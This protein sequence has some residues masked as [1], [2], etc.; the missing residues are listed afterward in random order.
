MTNIDRIK[1]KVTRADLLASVICGLQITVD[2]LISD[3]KEREAVIEQL[4]SECNNL[5]TKY[6]AMVAMR[7]IKAK[8]ASE[9]EKDLEEALELSDKWQQQ[10]SDI[11]SNYKAEIEALEMEL[12]KAKESNSNTS[13]LDVLKEQLG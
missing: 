6:N 10:C 11:E 5:T 2:C 9:L 12:L 1:A 13:C 3:L 8:R 7:N 4:Q